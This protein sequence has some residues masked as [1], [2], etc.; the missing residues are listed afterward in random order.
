M[1]KPTEQTA[2][3]ILEIIQVGAA[4]ITL[5]TFTLSLTLLLT[6]IAIFCIAYKYSVFELIN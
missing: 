2:S 1:K 5:S 6:P 4:L 3:I